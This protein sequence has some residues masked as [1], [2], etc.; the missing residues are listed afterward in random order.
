[1]NTETAHTDPHVAYE[2]L[3][4]LGIRKSGGGLCVY[5]QVLVQNNYHSIY[6]GNKIINDNY[7]KGTPE[8]QLQTLLGSGDETI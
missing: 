5:H 2:V 6:L 3:Y 8:S 7:N 1:M 4:T